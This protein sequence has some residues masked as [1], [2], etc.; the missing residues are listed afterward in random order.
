MAA[1]MAICRSETC[2]G[3]WG[4]RHGRPAPSF[5][6]RVLSSPP[7]SSGKQQFLLLH[8]DAAKFRAEHP[9]CYGVPLRSRG[10]PTNVAKQ[11]GLI[12]AKPPPTGPVLRLAENQPCRLG[13]VVRTG[14]CLCW[15]GLQSPCVT[16]HY[17][18]QAPPPRPP[19]ARARGCDACLGR[20][21]ARLVRRRVPSGAGGGA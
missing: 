10:T 8:A 2:E 15:L 17:M 19:A 20:W 9:L 5:W 13:P 3:A 11:K 14:L 7:P 21:R 6:C 12:T 4:Q 16:F 1:C 18:L